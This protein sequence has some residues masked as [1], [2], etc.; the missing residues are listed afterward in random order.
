M[1][2]FLFYCFRFV[3]E[4]TFFGG[5]HKPGH[6]STGTAVLPAPVVTALRY[7]SKSRIVPYWIYYSINL[8]HWAVE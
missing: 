3:T 4:F 2:V 8:P 5:G 6:F 1:I 7:G